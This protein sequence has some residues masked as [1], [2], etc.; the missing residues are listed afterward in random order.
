LLNKGGKPVGELEQQFLLPAKGHW[1]ISSCTY[2]NLFI[3]VSPLQSAHKDHF[4]K[5]PA[6][7]LVTGGFL[8]EKEL[9][10]RPI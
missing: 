4:F 7:L 9:K 5:T 3:T 2:I 8:L 6:L 10:A 1:R